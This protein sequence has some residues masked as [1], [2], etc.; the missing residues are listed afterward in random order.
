[1]Y[2][3]SPQFF[4]SYSKD[5]CYWHVTS[6]VEISE[7]PDQLASQKPADLDLHCFR[8]KDIS[9]FSMMGLISETTILGNPV[10]GSKM[11]ATKMHFCKMKDIFCAVEILFLSL[12]M[13]NIPSLSTFIYHYVSQL[14]SLASPSPHSFVGAFLGKLSLIS[15]VC[16]GVKPFTSIVVASPSVFLVKTGNAHLWLSTL[17]SQPQ[18]YRL[19]SP[20]H[21]TPET[22]SL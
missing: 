20:H 17:P 4:L 3:T 13:R 12:D 19:S 9:K 11:T 15:L 6:R 16:S 5:S 7:D 14:I 18:V 1:M 2:Y 10:L 21:D 22:K 8:K